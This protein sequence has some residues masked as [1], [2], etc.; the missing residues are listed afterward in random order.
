MAFD[1]EAF[2]SFR[3]TKIEAQLRWPADNVARYVNLFFMRL[4][5]IYVN[6]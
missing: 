4:L 5:L 2:E 1:E 6:Q 3:S